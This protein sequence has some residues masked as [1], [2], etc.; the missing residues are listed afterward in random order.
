MH[1]PARNAF[2]VKLVAVSLCCAF[3][4]S[5]VHLMIYGEPYIGTLKHQETK[6]SPCM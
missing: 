5:V 4:A 3:L 6:P 2:Q 1:Y